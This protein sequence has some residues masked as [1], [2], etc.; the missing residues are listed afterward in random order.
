MVVAIS[1]TR[2]SFWIHM[3]GSLLKCSGEQVRKA[4]DSEYLG[5]ELAKVLSQELLKSRER[6]GQRGF[7][8]VET[9]GKPEEEP[10]EDTRPTVSEAMG[11]DHESGGIPSSG[12][13]SAAYIPGVASGSG[14][15]IRMP[16][17]PEERPENLGIPQENATRN[18]L[19]SVA[20]MQPE[21]ESRQLQPVYDHL[22]RLK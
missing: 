6:S 20:G 21:A 19:E 13:H 17:I 2:T 12:T 14:G 3:R 1:D 18:E 5:T 8:D 11:V 22:G 15:A 4:T 7:V 9:E 10:P 16:T